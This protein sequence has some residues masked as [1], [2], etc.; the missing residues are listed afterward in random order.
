MLPREGRAGHW[1]LQGMRERPPHINGQLEVWSES[2]VGTEARGA[3]LADPNDYCAEPDDETT[4]LLGSG[5]TAN[6]AACSC[7]RIRS[8]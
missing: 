3:E 8:H 7:P 5:V 1:G 4:A 6:I 2:G